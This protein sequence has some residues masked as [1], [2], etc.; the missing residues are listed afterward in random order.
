MSSPKTDADNSKE[1][2]YYLEGDAHLDFKLD[3][4]YTHMPSSKEKIIMADIYEDELAKF[5]HCAMTMFDHMLSMVEKRLKEK[6]IDFISTK[7]KL[8]SEK[9]HSTINFTDELFPKKKSSK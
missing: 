2:E 5:S 4:T 7:R 9:E 6:G 8:K 1:E 3:I